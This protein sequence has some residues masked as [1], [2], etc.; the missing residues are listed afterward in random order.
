MIYVRFDAV[1]SIPGEVNSVFWFALVAR[2][3]Q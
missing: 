3:A 2:L 1:R